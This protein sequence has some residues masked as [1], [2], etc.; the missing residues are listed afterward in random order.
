MGGGA[1]HLGTRW[2]PRHHTIYD[3]MP[4]GKVERQKDKEKTRDSKGKWAEER[5]A[6]RNTHTHR[7]SPGD[8]A[9]ER[10]GQKRRGKEK[11][12][13]GRDRGRHANRD[14][15]RGRKGTNRE[16]CGLGA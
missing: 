3:L 11:N 15:I 16:G 12:R 8:R 4:Q 9:Q 7:G 5:R 6:V 2:A 1:A 14:Q 13:D 10:G